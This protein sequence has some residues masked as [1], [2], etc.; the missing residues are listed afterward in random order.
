MSNAEADWIVLAQDGDIG[1]FENLV[2]TYQKAVYRTHRAGFGGWSAIERYT[3]SELDT[4][5]VCRGGYVCVDLNCGWCPSVDTL[6]GLG[7]P[8][9]SRIGRVWCSLID[10]IWHSGI[11]PIVWAFS[12]TSFAVLETPSFTREKGQPVSEPGD[13]GAPLGR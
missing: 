9:L 3:E 11:S 7:F 10:P 5:G 8:D 4:A 6:R 2:N 1:A 13:G 12:T